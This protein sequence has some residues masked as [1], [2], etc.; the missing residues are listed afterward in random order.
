MSCH[1]YESV[2]LVFIFIFIR[3]FSFMDIM[4]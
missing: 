4:F 3:K 1:D 2:M